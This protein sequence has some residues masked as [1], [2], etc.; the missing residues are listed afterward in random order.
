MINTFNL[1]NY[2]QSEQFITFTTEMINLLLI[3]FN[4]LVTMWI[5]V[6]HS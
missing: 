2:I 4:G 5:T 3:E 1:Y 6:L